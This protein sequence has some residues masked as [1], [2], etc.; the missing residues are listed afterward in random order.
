[1]HLFGAAPPF[2]DSFSPLPSPNAATPEIGRREKKWHE[3][4]NAVAAVVHDSVTFAKDLVA[5][6]AGSDVAVLESS[7]RRC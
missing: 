6:V 1:M 3:F 2:V 7:P 4:C 5:L